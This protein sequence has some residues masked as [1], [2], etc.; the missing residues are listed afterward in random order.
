MDTDY[1]HNENTRNRELAA[2]VGSFWTD[3]FTEV[4]QVFS[5][6]SSLGAQEQHWL[7][8][9]EELYL[10][11]NRFTQPVFRTDGWYFL[12]LSESAMLETDTAGVSVYGGGREYGDGL[13]YGQAESVGHYS[14]DLDLDLVTASAACNRTTEPGRTLLPS[15]D[16]EITAGGITFFTDLFNGDWSVI[17]VRDDLGELT[18]RIVGVWLFKAKFDDELI[19]NQWGYTLGLRLPSSEYYRSYIN[20]IIDSSVAG[21]TCLTVRRLVSLLAGLPLV[22][23]DG[24]VVTFVARDSRATL[25]ITDSQ[26]YK[27]PL[28]A[29]VTV[30]VGDELLAGDVMTSDLLFFDENRSEMPTELQLP[31]FSTGKE[32]LPVGFYGSILWPNREVPLTATDTPSGVK[33]SFQLYGLPGDVDRMFDLLNSPNAYGQRLSSYLDTRGPKTQVGNCDPEDRPEASSIHMPSTINPFKLL[34]DL[35]F[36]KS[37]SLAIVNA[38][39]VGE[40]AI[41]SWNSSQLRNVIPPHSALVFVFKHELSAELPLIAEDKYAASLSVLV[42]LSSTGSFNRSRISADLTIDQQGDVCQ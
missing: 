8:R 16:F 21:T 18:D 24:E 34:R 6:F 40:F 14:W 29:S 32:F 4:D 30:S 28:T 19:F 27:F 10:S 15:L 36:R 7:T 33:I 23:S 42:T 38:S 41:R 11:I 5:L 39:Q 9:L 1:L 31:A 2:I 35:P 12:T 25:V 26:V 20:T 17:E 37:L 13:T 22:E 3:Q